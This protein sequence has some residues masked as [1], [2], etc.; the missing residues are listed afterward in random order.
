MKQGL[1]YRICRICETV[2]FRTYRRPFRKDMMKIARLLLDALE[3]DFELWE[4]TAP[5]PP[6]EGIR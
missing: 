6:N 3:R 5:T 1:A 2:Y 4:S